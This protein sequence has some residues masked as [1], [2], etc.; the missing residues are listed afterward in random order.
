[1]TEAR[2]NQFINKRSK[3]HVVTS[4]P[5]LQNKNV[6]FDNSQIKM[7]IYDVIWCKNHNY[8]E[9]NIWCLNSHIFLSC[10]S[11]LRFW[12]LK[13]VFGNKMK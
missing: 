11:H 3:A 7:C 2:P 8:I 6:F 9:V 5:Q 4:Q 1:M 13:K 12:T 10:V